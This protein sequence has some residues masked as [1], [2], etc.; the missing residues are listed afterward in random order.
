MLLPPACPD[1]TRARPAM[2]RLLIIFS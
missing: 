2:F 1:G